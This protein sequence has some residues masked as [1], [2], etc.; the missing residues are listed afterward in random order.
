M[1]VIH[2]YTG[3]RSTGLVTASPTS[4]VSDYAWHAPFILTYHTGSIL[5]NYVVSTDLHTVY[6]MN[7][8]LSRVK[9]VVVDQCIIHYD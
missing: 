7:S 4:T 2:W 3:S 8:K 5:I 1:I 6:L 9:V